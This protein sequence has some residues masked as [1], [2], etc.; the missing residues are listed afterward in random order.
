LLPLLALAWRRPAFLVPV[1]LLAGVVWA[2]ARAGWLLADE[3]PRP[4]E[5]AD[6]VVEGAVAD[7]PRV[8]EYGH[9]FLFDVQRGWQGDRPIRIPARLLL[10]ARDGDV[11]PRAGEAWR[12]TV[13]LRRPHGFQN[14][15]GFDYEAYLLREGIR[16]RGSVREWQER[17]P[18]EG[19]RYAVDRAREHLGE[20]IRA[21][22]PDHPQAGIVEA[23]ANGHARGVT[24]QQ[25]DVL[26]RTGTLHLVAI[27][28]L[29]IS[30]VAAIAFFLGRWLWSLPGRTV[31]WWPA[32]HA[33]AVAGLVAAAGYAAL[34]GFV[35]PTQRAL[36]MAAVVFGAMLWR[37]RFASTQVL[38]AALLAVL[39][40]DPLSVHAPGFWLSFAAVA[41]IF[42]VMREDR[43]GG[44]RRWLGLQ[45]AIAVG[46]LPVML[47]LFQQVSLIGPVANTLAIPV[48]D[49]LSVPLVLAGIVLSGAGLD[50]L[51]ALAW[52]GAAGLLNL[53][54]PAL[55]WLSDPAWGQWWQHRPPG[56]AT[57]CAVV[58][59]LLLLAP[60]AWP[61]RWLGAVWLLPALLVRPPGPG[62]GE[63]WMTMLDVGQGLAVV[64]RTR[65]HVAVFDP[66][67]RYSQNFDAGESVVVPYLRQAGVRRIDRLV[68][69]H[70]D[71]D[72]AGGAD[73]VLSAMP[74]DRIM[75]SVPGIAGQER[76]R[77]GGRWR[78]DDVEFEILNPPAGADGGH[79][80][81]SCVLMVRSRHGRLLL[82]G[83]IEKKAERR[84]VETHGGRLRA[85][86]MIAP[87]HGSRTSSS[88][89]F[90]Q[91]VR[92]Q[93]VLLPVGYRNVYRHPHPLVIE[94]YR[95][96]GARLLD[97]PA[98]GA[99][100]VRLTATGLDL[101]RYRDTHRRY[102]FAP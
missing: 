78:W 83:D 69:S 4:L 37:R 10:S 101:R 29:H 72:H 50:A 34:A 89:A 67:P 45:W 63:V 56:W 14:P 80:N 82:T 15:G 94:R 22:L 1:F 26:R 12:L 55:A 54:W 64:V 47:V 5:G 100:D 31:L 60:R 70:G 19:A 6:L 35:V 28:G 44:W 65:H 97:S 42:L 95:A 21:A 84:M 92:P 74:V 27:S 77:E 17:L 43:P 13:R 86:V 9:R 40:Y 32:Q 75:S 48:F 71:R 33:G 18:A 36:I 99:I 25:W 87:H 102:W 76:C 59:V 46:L 91:A 41:V 85:E 61:G 30:L 62:A 24:R 11:V 7:L 79:N 2:S 20:R 66:G 81:D 93:W 52:Q 53:L 38:A 88:P 3:L 49:L 57:A 73:S 58:G 23:L 16:A 98:S 90:V 8:T 68:I 96:Q 39:V 51:A